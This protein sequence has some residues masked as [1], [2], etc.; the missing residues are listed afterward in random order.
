[1]KSNNITNLA[2]IKNINYKSNKHKKIKWVVVV[3]R[4]L[5]DNIKKEK[6]KKNPNIT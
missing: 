3:R 6:K 1:V 2:N 4:G 5:D